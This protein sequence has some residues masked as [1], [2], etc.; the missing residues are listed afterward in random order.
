MSASSLPSPTHWLLYTSY[1]FFGFQAL[2]LNE[3]EGKEY[4]SAVLK[5]V[6]MENGDKFVALG[7]LAGFW[8][9]VQVAGL[10]VLHYVHKERR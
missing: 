4:G 7:V 3:F 8:V 1:F 6:G 10:V 2:I 5:D 9:G